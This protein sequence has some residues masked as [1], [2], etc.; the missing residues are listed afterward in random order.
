MVLSIRTAKILRL[1]FARFFTITS[2]HTICENKQNRPKRMYE[3]SGDDIED[4]EQY[5]KGGFYPTYIADEIQNGR[6]R[7]VHKLGFGSF[8][9]VWLAQDQHENR[10]VSLKFLRA[11]TARE[12][13]ESQI[14]LHL[15][16][17]HSG[18][19]FVLG[20]LD[21]FEVESPNGSHR[22]LVTE[23]LG[24]SIGT[25]IYE[26]SGNRLPRHISRAVAAQCVKGLAYLHSCGVVHGG[27]YLLS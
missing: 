7:I 18:H 4:L 3:W 22:C 13:A 12:T 9:T 14:L 2:T 25:V 20:L 6:Y 15:R 16:A 23:A 8:S 26:S 27:T 19:A 5:R 24:P 10:L 21:E 17:S 11:D 1:H